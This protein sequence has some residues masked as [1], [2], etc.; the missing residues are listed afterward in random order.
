MTYSRIRRLL[1]RLVEGL[2]VKNRVEGENYVPSD[3][4]NNVLA[5]EGFEVT[6]QLNG[7]LMP[8]HIPLIAPLINRW[9]APLPFIR[10]LCL[11]RITVARYVE[12]ISQRVQSVNIIVASRNESEHIEELIRHVPV[13]AERKDS[14]LLKEIQR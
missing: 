2:C 14:S 5:S 7:V 9:I 4:I 1:I 12:R 6:K 11:I 8:T 3:E 13:R 10:A